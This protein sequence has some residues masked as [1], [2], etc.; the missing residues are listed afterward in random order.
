M[1]LVLQINESLSNKLSM[2]S[3]PADS[4]FFHPEHR[5]QQR[6]IFGGRPP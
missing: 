3:L 6:R 5:R 4:T 2:R 1:T